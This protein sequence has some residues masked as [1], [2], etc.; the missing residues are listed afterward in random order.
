MGNRNCCGAVYYKEPPL[1][2]LQPSISFGQES[3]C[4]T[5]D[6]TSSFHFHVTTRRCE[7]F[8]RATMRHAP[9]VVF[10]S[11]TS[12]SASKVSPSRVTSGAQQDVKF[13]RTRIHYLK[14][15]CLFSKYSQ[16]WSARTLDLHLNLNGKSCKHYGTR[17]VCPSGR[18]PSPLAAALLRPGDGRARHG[19][20]GVV[21]GLPH[22]LQDLGKHGERGPTP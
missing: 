8:S 11:P 21:A 3:Y 20:L 12:I 1:I 13:K 15:L 4:E 2:L 18:N 19:D 7:L 16:L 9:Q 17:C 10:A 22:A 5:H 6:T 14:S